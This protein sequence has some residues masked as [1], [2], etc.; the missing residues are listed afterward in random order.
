M[1]TWTGSACRRPY[2]GTT[3][4]TSKWLPQLLSGNNFV[5]VR[6]MAKVMG[7]HPPTTSFFYAVQNH[8][9]CPEVEE[10]FSTYLQKKA[11]EL[12]GKE[13]VV[14]GKYSLL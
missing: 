11:D 3:L 9:V 1:D 6:H 13:V 5:K 8:Y 7:L 4:V 12:K 10:T 14:C 2:T